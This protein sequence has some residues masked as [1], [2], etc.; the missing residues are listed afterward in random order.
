MHR[1][2]KKIGTTKYLPYSGW[3]RK[4]IQNFTGGQY[5]QVSVCQYMTLK[6]GGPQNMR[7]IAQDSIHT[8]LELEYFSDKAMLILHLYLGLPGKN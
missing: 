7:V 6:Y 4:A 8:A 5:F 1:L 2:G 3:N